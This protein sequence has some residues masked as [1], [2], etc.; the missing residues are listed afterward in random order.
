MPTRLPSSP[1]KHQIEHGDR[2]LDILRLHNGTRERLARAGQHGVGNVHAVDVLVLD[3]G[4]YYR[5]AKAVNIIQLVDQAGHIV[6][7]N[8]SRGTIALCLGVI[9]RNGLPC[10][11]EVHVRP[12]ELNVKSRIAAVNCEFPAGTGDDVLD[13]GTGKAK[14]V[15][16]VEPTSLGQGQIQHFRKRIGD[17]NILQHIERRPV[18]MENVLFAERFKG[19]ALQARTDDGVPALT[20]FPGLAT[21]GPAAAATAARRASAGFAATA[22]HYEPPLKI[23]L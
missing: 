6:Q 1:N 14:T 4:G 11:R 8:Q 3:V 15:V 7:V 9:D 17:A 19:T 21:R 20:C 13:E 12:A 16:L 18:D 22:A 2:L 10:R 5:L 23:N